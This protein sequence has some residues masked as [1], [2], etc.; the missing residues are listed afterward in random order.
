MILVHRY[1]P[2]PSPFRH[3]APR[4]AGMSLLELLVVITLIGTLAALLLPAVQAAREASRRTVCR[5]HLRQVALAVVTRADTRQGELPPLW[6]TERPSPW[7]NFSWRVE[8]LGELEQ[9]SLARRLDLELLPLD[10]ANAPGIAECL[11]IFQCPSAP[12]YPRR[13]VNFERLDARH[14]G[15][16]AGACDYA[17]V[18]EVATDDQQLG[19]LAG[20]W[21]IDA[22]QPSVLGGSTV[23]L[24]SFQVVPDRQSPRR[25]ATPSNLQAIIDGL[26]RT[27][28]IAEQAGKPQQYGTKL[29]SRIVGAPFVGGTGDSLD[30]FGWRPTE[31]AWATAEMGTFHAAVNQDNHA[32][33][34]GFHNGANV[35][36][37]DGSVMLLHPQMEW[38]VL[39]ALLTR[40]GDEIISDRDWR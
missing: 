1:T 6:A 12:D 36:M 20:A 38:E 31:G 30:V 34:Y 22:T 33:P 2:R 14:A 3:I 27:V 24:N 11:P 19:S 8:L 21:R 23:V 18:F 4:R 17:A 10:A 26:S 25:R 5:N 13:S 29:L 15:L 16:Q 39:S 37:C 7:E 28:L 32:G 40:D 9:A 35:A